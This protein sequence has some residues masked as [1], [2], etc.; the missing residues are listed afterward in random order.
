[1]N[2]GRRP[3][4]TIR[5]ATGDDFD[6]IWPIF[7]AVV[8]AGD[9]YAIPR[10]IT[11]DDAR[12]YWMDAPR[13]TF[14]CEEDGEVLGSYIL[15]TNQPGAGVHVCNAGY[16]VAPAARG[17][18]VAS[19]MCEHSQ[20]FARRLGYRAMQFNLVVAT[21]EGAVRLWTN[22]GFTTVGRLPRAF[23]HPSLGDVDAF[24]MYKWLEETA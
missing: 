24:V 13:K 23:R 1:M 19:A 12:A 5:E 17:R 11:K 8:A 6:R 16:M 3:G 18:G 22:L 7:H 20:E 10:D 4:L 2:P 21:N 14:V 15:K 9:T